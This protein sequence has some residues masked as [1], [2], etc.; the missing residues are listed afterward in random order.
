MFDFEIKDL[1][2]LQIAKVKNEIDE[3]PECSRY[4]YIHEYKML[5]I[6]K[7]RGKYRVACSGACHFEPVA[8]TNTFDILFFTEDF[9]TA[10]AMFNSYLMRLFWDN[11]IELHTTTDTQSK[12]E[13]ERIQDNKN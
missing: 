5:F 9:E 10:V 11:R 2:K 12:D 13:M 6:Y 7:A 1:E 4:L 3:F 8:R